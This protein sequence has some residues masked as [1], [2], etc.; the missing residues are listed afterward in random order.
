MKQD[1]GAGALA[2][3]AL[4]LPTGHGPGRNSLHECGDCTLQTQVSENGYSVADQLSAMTRI[5]L[6]WR[7]A[8]VR[9][10]RP[11]PVS[12]TGE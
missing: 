12:K 8:A 11:G 4:A 10:C 9:L 5:L 6:H 7:A 1:S 3:A 2:T